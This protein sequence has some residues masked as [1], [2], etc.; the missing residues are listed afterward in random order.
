MYFSNILIAVLAA[1]V[2]SAVANPIP[3]NK[4]RG[5]FMLGGANIIR[6]S[7]SSYSSGC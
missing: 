6:H 1:L 7:E 2:G 3:G 4:N 5:S